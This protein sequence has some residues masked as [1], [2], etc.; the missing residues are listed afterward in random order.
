MQP[1]YQDLWDMAPVLRVLQAWGT[2]EEMPMDKLTRKVA[3]LLA[4]AARNRAS[5]SARIAT[6]SIRITDTQAVLTVVGPKERSWV[7]PNRVDTIMRLSGDDGGCCPVHAL[8]V[9]LTRTAQWR[10]A[11]NAGDYLLLTTV[12]PHRA[13]TS[14]AIAKWNLRT[15]RE[16]GVDT[17]VYKAHSIRAV[18]TTAAVNAGASL[19]AAAAG[20]WRSVQTMQRHYNRAQQK[21]HADPQAGPAG[22]QV[23]TGHIMAQATAEAVVVLVPRT[24]TE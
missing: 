22:T 23:T 20:K 18:A 1:R 7:R 4:I 9:Y 8:E 10:Q 6:A 2:D 17:I 5:D 12:A 24:N 21:P 14:Q 16:A 15:M 19:A 3:M 13:A 11:S